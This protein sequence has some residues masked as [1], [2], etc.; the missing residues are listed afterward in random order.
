MRA[1]SFGFALVAEAEKP[2]AKRRRRKAPAP[3]PHSGSIALHLLDTATTEPSSEPR[4]RLLERGPGA[5]T[6]VELVS[7]FLDEECRNSGG[8][9]EALI[10]LFGGVQGL[11]SFDLEISRAKGLSDRQAIFLLAAVEL[12]R[13]LHQ[14]PERQFWL[15]D[16]NEVAGFLA[17]QFRSVSDQQ[18][19]GVF[20]ADGSGQGLG[21]VECFRGTQFDLCVDTGPILR[22]AVCRKAT[23]LLVFWFRP[24]V[25]PEVNSRDFSFRRKMSAA[26][27]SLG[28]ELLDFLLLSSEDWLS[29]R[30]LTP[31]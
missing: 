13:R 22:E 28:F 23:S 20:F 26:C 29:L 10:H 27:E 12:G 4:A 14:K 24:T 1:T 2:A 8:P 17:G 16:P 6:D 15:T 21:F 31:W 30:R 9:G 25:K 3:P 19:L 18:V 7:I 11:A 5:L